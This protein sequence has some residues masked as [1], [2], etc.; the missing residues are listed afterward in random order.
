MLVPLPCHSP[1]SLR[2]YISRDHSRLSHQDVDIATVRVYN[3]L[4]SYVL[5]RVVT[6]RYR[7]IPLL[8]TSVSCCPLTPSPCPSTPP[9]TAPS[10][11]PGHHC[12]FLQLSGVLMSRVLYKWDDVMCNWIF[13]F[14]VQHNAPG[15]HQ[16]DRMCQKFTFAIVVFTAKSHPWYKCSTDSV[17]IAQRPFRVFPGFRSHR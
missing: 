8:Q 1:R 17:S 14:F 6:S 7:A 16:C 11:T 13:F 3:S 2:G 12:Y 9:P 4:P 10:L 5:V 15:I